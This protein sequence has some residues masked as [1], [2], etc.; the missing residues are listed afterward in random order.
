M[1]MSAYA[2]RRLRDMSDNA[3]GIVASELLAAAQGLDFHKP[4]Q[5]SARL[6]R[7]YDRLRAL[8][9]PCVEDRSLA[10]DIEAIRELIVSERLMDPAVVDVLRGEAPSYELR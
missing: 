8:S 4:L 1:S 5:T 10:P 6:Q 9:P 7:C 2:A 3:A